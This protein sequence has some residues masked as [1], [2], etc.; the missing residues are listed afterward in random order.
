MTVVRL[1]LDMPF[2]IGL[3]LNTRKTLFLYNLIIVFTFHFLYGSKNV[4][5]NCLSYVRL[6][7]IFIALETILITRLVHKDCLQIVKMDY[8]NIT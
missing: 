5:P 1:F 7:K 3:S 2:R 6:K 4:V 8:T